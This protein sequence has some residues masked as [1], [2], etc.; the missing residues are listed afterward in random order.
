MARA[1]DWTPS[2]TMLVYGSVSRRYKSG[3]FPVIP[4]NSAIPVRPGQAGESHL[5]T[6]SDRSSRAGKARFT[7]AGFYNDYRDK[8]VFG[9]ISDPIFGTLGRLVNVPKSRP[10]ASRRASTGR[11]PTAGPARGRVVFTHKGAPLYRLQSARGADQLR[12]RR[13]SEL[14]TCSVSA[15]ATYTFPLGNN[16]K[17]APSLDATYQS[18]SHGDFEDAS[19]YA[20]FGR[21]A[22]PRARRRRATVQHTGLR[23][24]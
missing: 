10:M 1:V 21:P 17:L 14:A 5:P 13:I 6:R 8:Q 18:R 16:L 3:A 7:I 19:Q 11:R 24:A 12:R 20:V 23:I 9:A 22:A 4:A 2:A 15:Q